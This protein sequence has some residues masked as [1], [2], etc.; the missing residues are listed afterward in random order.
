MD[1][2][3]CIELTDENIDFLQNM[4]NQELNKRNQFQVKSVFLDNTEHTFNVK[5]MRINLKTS[6]KKKGK[7]YKRFI[8]P[9]NEFV[10][11][12]ESND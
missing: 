8:L 4:I 2:E 3:L 9:S 1:K 7:R 10:F 6:F 5:K 11:I 12:G